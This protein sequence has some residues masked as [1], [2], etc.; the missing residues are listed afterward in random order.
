MSGVIVG[1]AAQPPATAVY[2]RRW[3]VEPLPTNP[4]NTLILQVLVT[5]L[6]DRGTAGQANVARLSDEAR[7]ITVKTRKAQ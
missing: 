4:N 6:L 2:T 1:N 7:V 5:P 3:S